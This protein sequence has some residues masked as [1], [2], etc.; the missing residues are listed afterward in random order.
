MGGGIGLFGGSFNPIH[1]GHLIVARAVAE[2]LRLSRVVFVPAPNPPHKPDA[3]LADASDRLEMVRLAVAG[4]PLLECGDIEIRRPGPSYTILTIQEYRQPT[5]DQE[6][7]WIIGADSLAELHTW[8]RV[9]ELVEL[10][11]I[12]TVARPGFELPDLGGLEK[13]LSREQVSRL[14]R[15]ILSTPRI[16]IS[17]TD[18]RRRVAEGRSIGYLVPTSV[19]Q[20]I[21]ERGLYRLGDAP[22]AAGGGPCQRN[23]G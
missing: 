2:M 18:I 20:Y 5:G 14:K 1:H 9:T 15:D 10:C 17:A 21:E 19:R 12:V 23:C 11:R 13:M 8:H 16:D 7:F 3:R 4:E 6:L 22:P